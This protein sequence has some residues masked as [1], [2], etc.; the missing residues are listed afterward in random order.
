[1]K[2]ILP[3]ALLY[4]AAVFS[5]CEKDDDANSPTDFTVDNYSNV[6][7]NG[8]VQ[9]VFNKQESVLKSTDGVI[10][11]DFTVKIKSTE[12]QRQSIHVSSENGVLTINAD[13]DIELSDGVV[14]ELSTAE[15]EE[16][17]LEK[18]QEAVFVGISNQ[19]QL[20]VVTEARSK[21]SLLDVAVNHLY[22]KTEGES[23]VIVTTLA[24]ELIGVQSYPESRGVLINDTILLVDD[25][26]FIVADNVKL[27]NAVWTVS[28]DVVYSQFQMTSCEYK[29]EGK[30]FVDAS[31]ALVRNVWINLE[32]ESEA[33]VWATESITGK[34]EGESTLNYKA[35]EGI[36]LS[37]FQI[38]GNAQI[39]PY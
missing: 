9:V 38:Q 34:G 5:S 3:V 28:S 19:D 15:L 22:C 30:T 25:S 8:Q 31:E 32:G 27:E 36:D 29:T 10:S 2:K 16:V 1:M 17:R 26:Y 11:G 7:V 4:I 12:N 24:E 6:R 35:F 20:N 39:I 13:G 21:L 18:D 23:E 37:G 33:T 14:I